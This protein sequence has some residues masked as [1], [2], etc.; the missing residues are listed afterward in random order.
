MKRE[1]RSEMKQKKFAN[2]MAA[3]AA[4]YGEGAI[5][6]YKQAKEVYNQ[7]TKRPNFAKCR[8]YVCNHD[9]KIGRNQFVVTTSTEPAAFRD[10]LAKRIAA[11]EPTRKLARRT[12]QH[13]KTTHK[14]AHRKAA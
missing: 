5:I 9:Y 13:H 3:L 4:K 7:K 12:I 10:K 8:D 1:E 14:P 6:T 11:G 2:Y